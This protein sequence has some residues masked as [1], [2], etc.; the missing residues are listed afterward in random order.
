MRAFFG[1]HAGKATAAVYAAGLLLAWPPALSWLV[2]VALLIFAIE[3]FR[4]SFRLDAAERSR[5]RRMEQTSTEL[6][7]NGRVPARQP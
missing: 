1:S 4:D 2:A 3:R 5:A 7:R 6:V